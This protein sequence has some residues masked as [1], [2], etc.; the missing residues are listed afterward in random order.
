M[1][2]K[3]ILPSWTVYKYV[4]K[5]SKR[6]VFLI[7]IFVSMCLQNHFH[8]FSANTDQHKK[9][10]LNYIFE[11]ITTEIY[12]PKKISNLMLAFGRNPNQEAFRN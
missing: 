1:S 2:Y 5:N 12:L 3:V 4:L 6:E 10:I 7:F 11:N 8:V 9:E